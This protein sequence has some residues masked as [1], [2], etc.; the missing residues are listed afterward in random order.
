[1]GVGIPP[2]GPG[3]FSVPS[4]PAPSGPAPRGR[5]PAPGDPIYPGT[6]APAPGILGPQ[7]G[8]ELAISAFP[9][10][11][12]IFRELQI[13]PAGPISGPQPNFPTPI[14]IAPVPQPITA[15]TGPG[16]NPQPL[17]FEIPSFRPQPS[18]AGGGS[19][20]ADLREFRPREAETQ[21]ITEFRPAETTSLEIAHGGDAERVRADIARGDVPHLTGADPPSLPDLDAIMAGDG[22]IA[23]SAQSAAKPTMSYPSL[24]CTSCQMT[25]E[26]RGKLIDAMPADSLEVSFVCPSA[27]EADNLA[28]GVDHKCI[29]L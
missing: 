16:L 12:D 10:A 17:P 15:P 25:E 4:P 9:A 28:R 27:D 3:A 20:I 23:G 1:M 29:P 22:K 18:S 6:L 13:A 19:D 2:I 24:P 21:I 11:L 5:S 7:I 14:P 8:S 26:E